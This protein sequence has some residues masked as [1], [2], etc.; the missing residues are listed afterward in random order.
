[1]S[2]KRISAGYPGVCAVCGNSYSAGD[3]IWWGKHQ[4]TKCDTCG[5]EATKPGSVTAKVPNS[6][7]AVKP[8]KETDFT[9]SWSDLK[10]IALACFD[11]N[12]PK[13]RARNRETI[14]DNLVRPDSWN[15]Y[16]GGQV[17]RWLRE[18]YKTS[19]IQGLG[20]AVPAREKRRR[21]YH[22][23]GDELHI[24]RVYAGE[25]NYMSRQTK[26]LSIPGVSLDV[27]MAFSASTDAQAIN[28]FNAWICKMVY[29]LEESGIDAEVT[30]NCHS[31]GSINGVH[32]WTNTRVKVKSE[33]EISDFVGISPMLSPAAFRGFMFT[34]LALHAN[35]RGMD[36][37]HGLGR[38]NTSSRFNVEFDRE[39][40]K[41]VVTSEYTPRSFPEAKMTEL[42]KKALGDT[43]KGGF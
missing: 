15:G 29:S 18:G 39:A 10:Q 28:E 23:E 35:A 31:N 14:M 38:G 26:H 27:R 36:V 11:G 5:P 4:K 17:E 30:L 22:D 37:S 8:G 1:M 2:L 43:V 42:F 40:Q 12:I 9:I 21:T 33:G 6:A 24:D 7:P 32:G 19:V 41:I 20:N 34:T 16:T 3:L 13:M 25:E